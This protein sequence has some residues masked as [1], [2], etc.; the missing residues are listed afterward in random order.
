MDSDNIEHEQIWL[1]VIEKQQRLEQILSWLTVSI[2]IIQSAW[3]NRMIWSRYMMAIAPSSADLCAPNKMPISDWHINCNWHKTINGPTDHC[4]TMLLQKQITKSMLA[5]LPTKALVL[6]VAPWCVFFEKVNLFWIFR[7][8]T[9]KIKINT[10]RQTALSPLL[11]LL[12]ARRS[13]LLARPSES[14][15]I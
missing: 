1:V 2:N 15:S 6:M 7:R 3:R 10:N 14:R 12:D 4:A 9:K 5:K 8:E 11:L 13:M